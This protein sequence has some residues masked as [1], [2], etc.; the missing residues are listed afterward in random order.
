MFNFF[1][2]PYTL[3]GAAV[4]VLFGILTFRSVLPEKRRW[5]QLLAPAFVVAAA[6]GLDFTVRTDLEKINAVINTC[7]KAVEEEDL[8]AIEAVI[9]DDYRD[10][11]HNTKRDLIRH[12]RTQLSQSLVEKNNKR[13]CLVQLS[14]PTA[15]ATLFATIIFEKDSHIAQNYKAW[16]MV[17]AQLSF[18]KQ[19]DKTWLINRIEIVE[20]DRQPT[21]WSHIR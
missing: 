16:L 10:S 21:N 14:A 6:F 11:H 2:Q 5:W 3:I 7:I 12:C 13:A 9:A 1:E 19:P 4:L 8:V 17:Q 18:Q 20:L 15:T